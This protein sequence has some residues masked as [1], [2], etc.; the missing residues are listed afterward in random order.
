MKNNKENIFSFPIDTKWIAG[1][2]NVLSRK[3]FEL[4]KELKNS[5]LF[6]MSD[7]HSYARDYW[8]FIGGKHNHWLLGGSFIKYRIFLNGK[9]CAVGPLRTIID[10]TCAL[11]VFHLDLN[12]GQ[13]ALAIFSRGEA[14]GFALCLMLEYKDGT[15]DFICSD[16]TWKSMCANQIYRSVCWEQQNVNQFFKG[17]VGP[18]EWDEHIDGTKYP[19]GWDNISFDDRKWGN[20][21]SFGSIL[22]NEKYELIDGN[23]YQIKHIKAKEIKS[24]GDNSFI[25]DFG[26]EIIG[27]IELLASSANG[28]FLELRLGEELLDS[29]RVRYQM[30]TDN[31]YQELWKFPKK[32]EKLSHFGIRAFR[33]AE[34]IGFEGEFTSD[35]INAIAVSAPFNWDDSEFSCSDDD[36]E[37]VWDL[38]KYS[39]AAT[40]MDVY[41]DCMSRERIC[42]E[43]D[44][45][46]T[47]LSHFAVEGNKK[48]ACRSIE[49]LLLHPTW[50]CEWR[51]IMIPMVYEY[52]MHT[53]ELDF[54]KRHYSFLR[55]HCLFSNLLKDDIV[56]EFPQEI[57]VDWPREYRSDFDFGPGNAVA[58]AYLYWNLVLFA[59]LAKYCG[60]ELEVKKLLISAAKLKEGFN[61]LLF[62]PATGLYVDHFGSSHSSFHANVFALRF[63]LV[64]KHKIKS[65]LDFVVSKGM[66]CSVFSSQFLLETLFIYGRSEE[67]VALMVS[68]SEYSWLNMLKQGATITMESWSTKINDR[69]SFAHPWGTAP[70]NII[71]RHLFGLRPTA[72]GWSKYEFKPQ[73]GGIKSAKIKLPTPRGTFN[74]SFTHDSQ[75]KL[76]K[77]ITI[78][79][80][81]PRNK[82][83]SARKK[84]VVPK[85][86]VLQKF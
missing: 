18:G 42:Y 50:P 46:I 28:D 58:N 36:L 12:M 21:E 20:S 3:E 77:N 84:C 60:Y 52:Y 81:S 17:C 68:S 56:L 37:K 83:D 69:L 10:G 74:A 14:K 7:P 65:V 15:K 33:Y 27:G 43:A 67:A 62:N 35:S 30:R 86:P 73:P 48:V 6:I 5:S 39:I 40:N 13:N 79:D 22:R 76:I 61:K 47:M 80:E 49:Y 85:V 70:A 45:Y 41:C 2:G 25:I 4:K 57:I 63:G 78:N 29:S 32:K 82:P 11:Q 8:Q 26:K 19:F 16:E 55:D 54:V 31:C 51:M 24:L 59:A 75:G 72:P 38:C 34:V 1:A 53:G 66:A 71:A 44:S 9:L 64:P 23:N